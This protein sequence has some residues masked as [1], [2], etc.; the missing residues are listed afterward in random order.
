MHPRSP[1]SSFP[2]TWP[3]FADFVVSHSWSCQCPSQWGTCCCGK[4]LL[5]SFAFL[6]P[7]PH[8][9]T[10]SFQPTSPFQA[11]PQPPSSLVESVL[12][13]TGCSGNWAGRTKGPLLLISLS[14]T[15]SHH[16]WQE[17]SGRPRHKRPSAFHPLFYFLRPWFC[18]I[19]K[20]QPVFLPVEQAVM[21]WEKVMPGPYHIHKDRWLLLLLKPE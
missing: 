4:C 7:S 8:L 10:L 11:S 16:V 14:L 21:R 3:H 18:F 2:R 13:A 17:T 9:W 6:P 19:A 5:L 1:S 12:G 15:K 20:H